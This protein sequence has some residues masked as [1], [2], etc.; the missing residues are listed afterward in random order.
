MRYYNKNIN[1]NMIF[2]LARRILSGINS[3]INHYYLLFNDVELSLL[4]SSGELLKKYIDNDTM[5]KKELLDYVSILENKLKPLAFRC[6]EYEVKN[7][8]N[9]VSWLK[10]GNYK[11]GVSVISSTFSQNEEK[12]FC[13]S[14]IG[15]KYEVNIDAFVAACEKDAASLKEKNN[16]ASLYTIRELPNGDV[17]NSYNLA[18]PIITPRQLIE[19]SQNDYLSNHN[20]IILDGRFVK[21]L[22]IVCLSSIYAETAEDL[23]EKLNVPIEFKYKSK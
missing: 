9:Y 14:E 10:D 18:T 21:P 8:C 19:F 11:S 4:V 15:I 3:I 12:I 22:S 17:I 2:V 5:E 16:R 7:G 6:W 23:S 13:N 1:N 20:E